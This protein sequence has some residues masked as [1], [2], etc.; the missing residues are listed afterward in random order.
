MWLCSSSRPRSHL[1]SDYEQT[2]Q[3]RKQPPERNS[4]RAKTEG[5][6]RTEGR[7]AGWRNRSQIPSDSEKRRLDSL[8]VLIIHSGAMRGERASRAYVFRSP[9]KPSFVGQG[10][11]FTDYVQ[12][13]ICE[14]AARAS[15][16]EQCVQ[17]VQCVACEVCNRASLAYVKSLVSLSRRQ[18]AR[19]GGYI[20]APKSH[21]HSD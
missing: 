13:R 8:I 12:I 15:P 11:T 16:A 5:R 14:I 20:I 21:L 7:S 6:A 4:S 1:H 9:S 19:I 2:R 17:C 18:K 10:A 3:M